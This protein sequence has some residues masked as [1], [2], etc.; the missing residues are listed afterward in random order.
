[1]AAEAEG[2]QIRPLDGN[3]KTRLTLTG[4]LMEGLGVAWKS[5]RPVKGRGLHRFRN[6]WHM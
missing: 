4:L 3:D 5:N 1:M 2:L 6:Q